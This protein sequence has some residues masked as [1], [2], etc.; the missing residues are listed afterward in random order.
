MEVIGFGVLEDVLG[1]EELLIYE[2]RGEIAS[3][4]YEDF[5]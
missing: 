1:I 5:S 4:D 2:R 3:T